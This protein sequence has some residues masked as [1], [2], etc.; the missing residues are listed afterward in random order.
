MKKIV[1]I[2]GFIPFLITGQPYTHPTTGQQGQNVGACMVSTCSGTYYDNGGA[3]SNYSNNINGVYQTFCPNTAGNCIRANFTSFNIQGG[4]GCP[5]DYFQINNGALQNSPGIVGGC[6]NWAGAFGTYT[7]TDASGCLTF[8]FWSNASTQF[9]GWAAT[10]SCVACAGP[11]GTDNNDCNNFT[12]L[13][14]TGSFPGTSTGPGLV[15]E[16]CINGATTA[17]DCNLSENNTNWYAFQI[18]TSGNLNLLINP[19]VSTEDYDFAIYGPGVSCVALGAP[20]RC[21]YACYPGC[22]GASAPT[23]MNTALD[24]VQAG[25]AENVL[26]DGWVSTLPV[27]SGQIYYLM[28]NKWSAGGSGYSIDWSGSTADFKCG[29]ALPIELTSFTTEFDGKEVNLNWDLQTVSTNNFIVE[30]SLDG[31]NFTPIGTSTGE[32]SSVP[33]K[34]YS[35]QDKNF[36]NGTLYY[37][38]RYSDFNGKAKYS[39]INAVHINLYDD[40]FYLHSEP[41][42]D[43]AQVFFNNT[44]S[45][46][47]TAFLNVYDSQGRIIKNETINLNSGTNEY[48]IDLTNFDKGVYF[49]TVIK[50]G[51]IFRGKFIKY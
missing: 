24:V 26:G 7:S 19:I 20:I 45:S 35:Y 4:A 9:S 49:L 1:Y 14:S 16:G 27:I 40:F 34:K 6:G 37:R 3:G 44:T 17:T 38:I 25:P 2:F 43:K 29:G 32:K 28:I 10:L 21:S 33:R 47:Q 18:N 48:A 11:N 50:E 31:L 22:G 51:Q 8:R 46:S 13:C 12:Q 39:D 42:M 23:G 41:G 15:S 30:K 36:S 5:F